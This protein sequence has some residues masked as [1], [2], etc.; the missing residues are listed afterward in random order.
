MSLK[1][2]F[3]TL[4][5]KEQICLTIF[6]LTIFSLFV[7]IT[8][9]NLFCFE[10][11]KQ[12][13]KEK[14]QYFYSKYKEYIE[15]V[16]YFQNFCLLQYEEMVRRMAHQIYKFHRESIT[17]YDYVSNFNNNLTTEDIIKDFNPVEHK[18][19]SENNDYIFFLCYSVDYYCNFYKNVIL[20][21]YEP[22]SSLIFSHDI[23][24]S[25][26]IPRYNLKMIDSPLIVDVYS[27][28]S[29]SFNGSKLYQSIVDIINGYAD[30]YSKFNGVD[31]YNYYNNKIISEINKYI[32]Y[33]DNFFSDKIYM[34]YNV[35]ENIL[36]EMYSLPEVSYTHRYNRTSIVEYIKAATGFYSYVSFY[37]NKLSFISYKDN[38]YFYFESN[39]IDNFLY[40]FHSRLSSFFDMYFIPIKY[41]NITIISPELCI[42]FIVKQ[43]KYQ[44]TEEQINELLKN[45]IK[46]ES[47]ITD[48]FM[49]KNIFKKQ[50]NIEEVLITEFNY[51]LTVKNQLNQGIINIEG[52]PYYYIKYTYPNFNTLRE[53]K[54]SY[55]LLDQVNYFLFASFKKPIKY[56][57]FI[58]NLYTNCFLVMILMIYHIWIICLL[59]NIL[60]FRKVIIQLTEPIN[61]L[62]KAIET[63][64]MKDDN[65]FKYNYDDFIND[66]FLTTKEL[67]LGQ[68]N[69]NDE[70][71]L[72]KFNIL[73]IPKDKRKN[74]DTNRYERNLVINNNIMNQLINEQLN[75]ID[76]S[77]NIQINDINSNSNDKAYLKKTSKR[78]DDK[79]N[80]DNLVSNTNKDNNKNRNIQ[81]DNINTVKQNNEEIEREPYKILFKISEYL[82]YR[83]NKIENNYIHIINNSIKDESKKSNISKI[84]NNLNINNS[85]KTNLKLKKTIVKGDIPG[86]S[87]DNENYSINM[88]DNDDISYLWYMEAKKKKNKSF[89][90]KVGK[91][92]DELF[93]DNNFYRTNQELFKNNDI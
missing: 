58:L 90:Y 86:K 13:Y 56:S 29:I 91:N 8:I 11:L 55:F 10:I 50:L 1:T 51:F 57:D 46:G 80:D 64:S 18:N 88:L 19:I 44:I 42:L 3:L 93:I 14:K 16:F 47:N 65:I 92:Y 89:D 28:I 39:M 12:N 72:G 49:N 4:S 61:K 63:S 69:I 67:L 70:K 78:S 40:F 35:F 52:E 79:E 75:M 82:N 68:I 37:D 31:L 84:N 60:I 17:F 26:N 34:A 66:L 25:F 32:T 7:I 21:Y 81:S 24:K 48:C 53:F 87:D 73:S 45:I 15:S 76:F 43:M 41:L 74:I 23:D 2:K 38:R 54:T 6:C 5:I 71:G 59:I 36:N 27:N 30:D 9:I 85:L 77:K 62:Q 20:Q 22:L 33:F 83:Q